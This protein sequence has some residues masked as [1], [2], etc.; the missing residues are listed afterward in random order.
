MSREDC[1]KNEKESITKRVK[2]EANKE[3]KFLIINNGLTDYF[4]LT[5]LESV[6]HALITDSDKLESV[7]RT[8]ID[9]SN[10]SICIAYNSE[11]GRI[12]L[13]VNDIA[14]GLEVGFI[15]TLSQI[16]IRD[17]LGIS[18]NQDTLRKIKELLE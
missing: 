2:L 17:L 12:Q 10:P 4:T 5:I 3:G 11:D 14:E 15:T 7:E 8:V 9:F 13:A 1:G 16:I 18:N 6:K